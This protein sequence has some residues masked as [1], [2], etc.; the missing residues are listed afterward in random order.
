MYIIVEKYTCNNT[1]GRTWPF[2]LHH[3]H[4][5]CLA[6]IVVTGQTSLY[7]HTRMT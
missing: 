6:E 2:M 5:T 4:G 7:R 1:T 3:R